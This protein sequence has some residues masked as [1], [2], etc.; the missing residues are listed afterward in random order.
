MPQTLRF[1]QRTFLYIDTKSRKLTPTCDSCKAQIPS[2][3][4][5]CSHKA[6]FSSRRRQLGVVTSPS[7]L[8]DAGP[9][10]LG[11]F[12]SWHNGHLQGPSVWV[13]L[14]FPRDCGWPTRLCRQQ[15]T[16]G[17]GLFMAFRLQGAQF[18]CVSF[19]MVI[20]LMWSPVS[21]VSC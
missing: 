21:A 5:P 6:P 4:H 7:S 2:T 15:H 1:P 20:R 19:L 12:S 11:L 17:T 8:L 13:S 9:M 10:H 14:V 16:S 18:R 3:V